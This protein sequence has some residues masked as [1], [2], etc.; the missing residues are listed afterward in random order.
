MSEAKTITLKEETV[1]LSEKIRT[2]IKEVKID[3]E[4]GH[5]KLPKEFIE[6][7]LPEGITVETLQT[8]NKFTSAFVPAASHAWGEECVEFKQTQD[9]ENK[10]NDMTLTVPVVGKDE[11]T[12]GYRHAKNVVN[13]QTKETSI[14]YGNLSVKY[15]MYATGDNGEFSKVKEMISAR[16]S[17]LID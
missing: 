17:S 2:A 7:I 13:P 16:A 15:D 4:T 10:F 8:L 9:K 1:T 6:T 5:A 3:P 12:V 11:W 14:K